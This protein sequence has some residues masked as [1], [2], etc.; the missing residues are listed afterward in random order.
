MGASS[1][2]LHY[3]QVQQNL[4]TPKYGTLTN[5]FASKLYYPRPEEIERQQRDS[6]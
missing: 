1:V 4:L 6:K 3:T 5:Y 2:Q